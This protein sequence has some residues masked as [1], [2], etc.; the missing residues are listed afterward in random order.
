LDNTVRLWEAASGKLLRTLEG[1]RSGVMSV[2]F[3]GAGRT[4][5]SGSDDKTVRLWEAASGKLLH[6]LEGHLGPVRA[7]TFAP[8]GGYL[9]AAGDAGRLQ[10]WDTA[11]GETF[12]YLY[13]FGPGATLALLP[14]GRFDGTPDALR[15][16]CYTERGTLNSLPAEDLLKEFHAPAAVHEVLDRYHV[17]VRT[18]HGPGKA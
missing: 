14:D 8:H 4:L 17:N 11:R 10:F 5:A 16:L 2:A 7:V 15:Y 12:L 13:T 6:T 3:D 18:S 9:V 1:H